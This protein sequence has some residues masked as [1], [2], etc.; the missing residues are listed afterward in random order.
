MDD[1]CDGYKDEDFPDLDWYYDGDND[2][3]GGGTIPL[4][5]KISPGDNWVHQGGD[6]RNDDPAIHPGASEVLNGK[7]D[8]CNGQKDEGFPLKNWYYDGGDL[9]G[10]GYGNPL[11]QAFKPDGPWVEDK[12][13]DCYPNDASIYPGAPEQ[14][15]NKDDDCDGEVDEDF[16]AQTW[17]RDSDRD[18]WGR[19]DQ[20]IVRPL[21]PPFYGGWSL[22][23]GDCQ[24]WNPNVNPGANNCPN[25]SGARIGVNTRPGFDAEELEFAVL[26]WPI[27]S[28]DQFTIELKGGDTQTPVSL[29][30]FDYAGRLIET[31]DNL[32]VGQILKIGEQYK[33][34][35]YLLQAVQGNRR[36][37]IKLIKH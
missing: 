14:L 10:W 24:D 25:G 37:A 22:Q 11:V 33:N 31:Q 36:K 4:K 13:G 21:P 19:A 34:G 15:N 26:A 7:D 17:Y 23:A 2:G 20:V 29:K 18:G 27:P 32:L 3:W 9:D 16:P 28:V 5:R 1:D 35:M 8:N 6:C 30:L 12:G